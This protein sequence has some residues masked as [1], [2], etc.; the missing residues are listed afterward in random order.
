[1]AVRIVPPE[2]GGVDIDRE[3]VI[4][5]HIMAKVQMDEAKADQA[6][7]R[8]RLVAILEEIDGDDSGHRTLVLENPVQGYG[9]IIYQRRVSRAPDMERMMELLDQ[10]DLLDSCT[11]LERVPDE[12]AIMQ[13]VYDGRLPESLL[14]EMYPMKE[15]YAVV[16][17]KA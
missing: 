5:R 8:D 12:D 1:M 9:S 16:V 14:I 13:A 17:K 7:I 2:S 4:I 11:K 15:T 6:A 3:M 10:N